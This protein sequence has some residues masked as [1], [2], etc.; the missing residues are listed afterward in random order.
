MNGKRVSNSKVTMHF[1]LKMCKFL[2]IN[3]WIVIQEFRSNNGFGLCAEL[4]FWFFYSVF[5]FLIFLL[6]LA[7]FLP[8]IS[9]EAQILGVLKEFLPEQM[10]ILIGNTLADVLVK[11]KGYMALGTLLLALW[12]SSNAVNSMIGTLNRIHGV[13]ETRPYWKVKAISL[14]LTLTLCSVFICTFLL[15]VLGPIITHWIFSMI[16]WKHSLGIVLS[17]F[18]FLIAT[19]G[20]HVALLLVYRFGPDIPRYT[21]YNLPGTVFAI[22][23]EIMSSHLFSM[24]LQ[25]VAPYNKFY[26]AL[27]TVIAFMTW[28]Y[29]LGAFI[30]MG[31]QINSFLMRRSPK[32]EA[33]RVNNNQCR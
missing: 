18:R 28:L 30:L 13:R 5:P 14:L 27:G 6:A 24:Y 29:T 9:N 20:L 10:Y 2:L 26:G 17:F 11:P 23:G 25:K 3:V 22:L 21:I 32:F 4:A 15:L 33:R 1:F 19:L 31:G 8:F 7:G 12:A 16:K